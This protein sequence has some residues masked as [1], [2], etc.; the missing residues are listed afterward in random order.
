MVFD[1]LV[2]PDGGAEPAGILRPTIMGH[3]YRT[4][5]LV[6][7][8]ALL[9][10]LLARGLPR[11]VTGMG[12]AWFTFFVMFLIAAPIGLANGHDS[13]LV[14]FQT[15]FVL[16][17]GGMAILM[18]GVPLARVTSPE[19]VGK[20]A[21]IL[22]LASVVPDRDRVRE[23]HDHPARAPAGLLREQPRRRHRDRAVVA[24]VPAPPR[25]TVSPVAA[26]GRVRVVRADDHLRDRHGPTRRAHRA[27]RDARVRDWSSWWAGPG[28]GGRALA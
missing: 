3:D 18:A 28:N 11:R 22:G 8:L 6:I 4:A 17:A 7:V 15:K 16:E 27:G 21:W 12:V 1:A 23:P 2:Y 14:I 24:R 20:A 25:R 13:T 10:R 19:F 26:P 9:A 5:D